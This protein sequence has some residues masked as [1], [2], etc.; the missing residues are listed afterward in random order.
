ME[1]QTKRRWHI[2]VGARNWTIFITIWLLFFHVKDLGIAPPTPIDKK[3]IYFYFLFKE[4]KKGI[5]SF[6]F[7]INEGGL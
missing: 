4:K 5:P 6:F 7:S 1:F 2:V 3:F